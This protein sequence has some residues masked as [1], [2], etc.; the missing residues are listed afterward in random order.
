MIDLLRL[1]EPDAWP[2]PEWKQDHFGSTAS[3]AL[4]AYQVLVLVPCTP[5]VPVK[6]SLTLS[7]ERA[8]TLLNLHWHGYLAAGLDCEAAWERARVLFRGVAL[9]HALIEAVE[10]VPPLDPNEFGNQACGM[11]SHAWWEHETPVRPH[12]AGCPVRLVAELRG[13]EAE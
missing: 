3:A 10:A 5:A 6:I 13:L 4:G 1:I 8:N 9:K 11:C 2:A 12:Y 7:D